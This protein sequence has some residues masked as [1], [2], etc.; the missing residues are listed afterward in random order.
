MQSY[1]DF[2]ACL[3]PGEKHSAPSGPKG[4]GAKG[5][6]PRGLG[7]KGNALKGPRP[8]G[9]LKA[10]KPLGLQTSFPTKS[11][12]A[13][14]SVAFGGGKSNM[15][16]G[17]RAAGNART[18]AVSGVSPSGM[19]QLGGAQRG[20]PKVSQ[21]SSPS[22]FV[23]G[24]GRGL[25]QFSRGALTAATYPIR[26][27]PLP[28]KLIGVGYGMGMARKAIAP[29]LRRVRAGVAAEMDVRPMQRRLLSRVYDA[30]SMP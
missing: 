2:V 3:L 9:G 29:N 5:L 20:W 12:P 18:G 10:P 6:G 15:Y 16:G 25:K 4:F 17:V 7:P 21:G 28:A 8:V 23:T 27:L 30:D 14:K 26:V 24:V 19:S 1:L 13:S 11:G 22:S